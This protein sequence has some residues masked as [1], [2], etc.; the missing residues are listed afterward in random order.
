MKKLIILLITL[1]LCIG[2]VVAIH[3]NSDDKAPLINVNGTPKVGCSITVDDLLTYASAED[4]NLKNLFVEENNIKSIVDN[5]TATFV[6]VDSHNNVSKK[7]VSVELD[8]DI[9]NY[10]LELLKDDIETQVG[11]SIN[12]SDYVV[13]KNNCGW[14]ID[15]TIVVEGVDYSSIG[16]YD[17][18][19]SAK[20]YE[21]VTPIYASIVVGDYESPNISLVE[22]SGSDSSY[23]NY[24]DEYFNKLVLK[25]EDNK[26]D[27][28]DLIKRVTSNWRS[29]LD[30]DEDGYVSKTGT[31]T[32]TFKVVDSDGHTGSTPYKLTLN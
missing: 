25:V 3:F 30:A 21:N 8:S 19:I 27:P 2:V 15:D 9:T 22:D 32:I 31:F 23:M 6:A 12:P 26:D 5:R 17:V 10:H 18:K 24:D 11:T 28:I 29:V 16:V 4:D 13:L 14:D 7:S 20:K 1:V